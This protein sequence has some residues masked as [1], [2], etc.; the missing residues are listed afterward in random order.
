M[1]LQDPFLLNGRHILITGASSGIGKA[2]SVLFASRGASLCLL[3]RDQGRLQE[4]LSLTSD[5]QNHSSVSVDLTDYKLVEDAVRS[6]VKEKGPISGIVNCAGISTTLPLNATTIEKMEHFIRTNVIG[7]ISLTKQ[8][9]KPG[10]FAPE[11]GSIVFLSSVMGVTG[12]K[13]KT[14][15]SLTKGALISSVRSLAIELASK[16]IRVNAV[17]PGVVNS[18]MSRNAVYSRDDEALDKIRLLH[19]LGL[20]EPDDVANACMFLISDAS[21]WITGTNVI[22]D[23]GYLAK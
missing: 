6:I 17:S 10:N 16:K 9:L 18:P 7:P 12:E 13:G 23:G 14:L 20:G 21:K 22:V 4:T 19:P 5:P 8:V 3:G 2:C 11:G 15:Y 1:S